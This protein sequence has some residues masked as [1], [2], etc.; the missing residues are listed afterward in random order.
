MS[1]L[2]RIWFEDGSEVLFLESEMETMARNYD[3]D[4]DELRRE[5]NTPLVDHS[6]QREIGGAILWLSDE[7]AAA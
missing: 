4:A 2:Y 1:N 3:F 7:G 6:E 5:G